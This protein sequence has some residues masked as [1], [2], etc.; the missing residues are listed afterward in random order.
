M[1]AEI[2]H[3]G[4][5]AEDSYS[6]VYLQQGTMITDRDWNAL[7]DRLKERLDNVNRAVSASGVPKGGL[8]TGFADSGGP[9][10]LWSA[11]FAAKGGWV[12]ADGVGGEAR[13]RDADADFAYNNQRDLPD[14]TPPLADKAL[15]YADIWDKVVTAFDDRDLLDPGLHGAHTCFVTQTLVQIKRVADDSFTEQTPMR[16]A[17]GSSE[18]AVDR[19]GAL[20]R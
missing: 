6:G 3:H 9:N 20:Q 13:P 18:D 17:A 2:S 7:C 11:R 14:L 8:L 10:H 12:V 15:L 19:H 4:F 1:K 16:P 5:T